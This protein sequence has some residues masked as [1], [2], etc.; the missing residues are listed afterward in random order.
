MIGLSCSL[1]YPKEYLMGTITVD[2]MNSNGEIE[3]ITFHF[4]DFPYNV[5]TGCHLSSKNVDKDYDGPRR[6]AYQT[7]GYWD[8]EIDLG[9]RDSSFAVLIRET[10]DLKTGAIT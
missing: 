6:S 7:K 2:K 5:T 4:K 10:G 9:D 8:E 1:G 3:K